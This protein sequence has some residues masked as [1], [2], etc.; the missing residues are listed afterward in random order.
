MIH[1]KE[2]LMKILVND[3]G[4]KEKQVGGVVEKLLNMEESIQQS[5]QIWLDE[6]EMPEDPVF[7][8]CNPKNLK[9]TYPLKPPAV[10]LLLDWI[11]KEPREALSALHSEYGRY[12]E[13][14][15]KK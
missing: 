4:Y 11:R 5:F 10:F 1:S 7:T 14:K 2:E 13:P 12:P 15:T 3:W 9:E 6:G 8:G